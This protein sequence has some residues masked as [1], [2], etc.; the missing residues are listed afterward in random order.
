V[1][2]ELGEHVEALAK[3]LG[4]FII[5]P[6]VGS[7]AE[8]DEFPAGAAGH[9][10]MGEDL[11]APIIWVSEEPTTAEPYLIALHELGHHATGTQGLADI[12]GEALAWQ[13]AEEMS[14]IPIT[15]HLRAF[16]ERR[17]ESYR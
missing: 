6:W 1:T 10:E 9:I 7:F 17:L 2:A 16:I 12:V 3:E 15:P 5:P 11:G 13:W 8:A 14:L 4:V